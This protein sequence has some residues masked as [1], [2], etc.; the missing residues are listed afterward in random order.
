M[1]VSVSL[2][3]PR[4][5]RNGVTTVSKIWNA[6]WRDPQSGRR[7]T[8]TTGTANKQS[9]QLFASR[10]RD[11]LYRQSIGAY[12][13]AEDYRDLLFAT[14]RDKFLVAQQKRLRPDTVDAYRYSL[15]AFERVVKPKELRK[16]DHRTIHSF[17]SD[18]VRQ[19]EA[20]TT[21]KDL[22]HVRTFLNWC[23]RQSYIAQAP[24][25]GRQFLNVDEADPVWVPDKDVKAVLTALADP[26]L[27]LTKRSADWWLVFIRVA[28]FTGMRRSELLGLKWSEVDFDSGAVRV[29]RF[30]SKGRRDR[31]YED[32][33][34]LTGML[35]TW[36]DAHSEPPKPSDAVLP[37]DKTPRGLYTDWYRI[38]DHAGIPEERRFTPHGCRSSCVSEL[39]AAGFALTTVRDWV[40]HSSVVVTERHYAETRTDRKRVAASRKVV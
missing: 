22:R 23:C 15:L 7:C 26:A 13:P 37:F 30:T 27:V 3:Q 29:I 31:L 24:D 19:V 5:T 12:D 17:V 25:F 21:N 1:R 38:L 2:F 6:A 36:C 8:K 34:S 10:L 16:I 28:L 40:G 20:V 11:K 4:V 9:A 32:A 33:H 35:R 39:L 18:R 14:A